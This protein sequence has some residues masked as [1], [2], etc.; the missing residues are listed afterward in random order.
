MIGLRNLTLGYASGVFGGL[1]FFLGI[2]LGLKAGLIPA[3]AEATLLAKTFLYKQMIWGGVWGILLAVPILN[4]VW[5]LK[6]FIIGCIATAVAIF[7]FTPT[8]LAGW[9]AQRIAIAVVLN[10]VFWG[11]GAAFWYWL[12]TGGDRR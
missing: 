6:G 12:V 2:W 10:G 3:Q 7:V 4:R 1:V 8:G 5:W 11:I 9:P